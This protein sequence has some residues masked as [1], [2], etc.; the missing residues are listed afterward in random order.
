MND[1][2]H[3]TQSTPRKRSNKNRGP[4]NWEIRRYRVV[5]IGFGG[6]LNHQDIADA[7]QAFIA[8]LDFQADDTVLFCAI[9]RDRVLVRD[10][11]KQVVEQYVEEEEIAPTIEPE[12]P[13]VASREQLEALAQTRSTR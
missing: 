3:A 12:V 6:R 11:T 1:T 2:I 7:D 4:R 9:F 13:A 5:A 10:C 8:F